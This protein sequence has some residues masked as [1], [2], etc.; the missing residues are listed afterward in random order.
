MAWFPIYPGFDDSAASWGKGRK[1]NRRNGL[2]LLDTLDQARAANAK[3]VLLATWNDH[4]E[5]SATELSQG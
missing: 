5:G 3:Y 4:E 2:T 1:M